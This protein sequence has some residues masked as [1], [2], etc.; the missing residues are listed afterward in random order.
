MY[1]GL[2]NTKVHLADV[3]L[4]PKQILRYNCRIHAA[5]VNCH[6]T[7]VYVKAS[8]HQGLTWTSI[9]P[10]KHIA[11]SLITRRPHVMSA[12]AM[13]KVDMIRMR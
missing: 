2:I 12:L 5:Q 1:L 6:G 4:L 7:H 11:S 10:D 13:N 8:G 9:K 3:Q